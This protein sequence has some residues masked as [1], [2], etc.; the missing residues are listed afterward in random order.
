MAL[1]NLCV[2]ELKPTWYRYFV[3]VEAETLEEAI[4]KAKVFDCEIND[5]ET[6]YD[7]FDAIKLEVLDERGYKTLYSNEISNTS[8]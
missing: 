5:S 2:D 3:E 4:E 8:R 6:F 1:F 7:D